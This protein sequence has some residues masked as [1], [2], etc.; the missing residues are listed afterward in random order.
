LEDGAVMLE[1]DVRAYFPTSVSVNKA[2][3]ALIEIIPQK[4]VNRVAERRSPE[5]DYEA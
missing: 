3:R 1:P 5:Q 4:P 2:L